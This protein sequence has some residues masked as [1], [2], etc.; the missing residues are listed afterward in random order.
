MK[1]GR[2]VSASYQHARSGVSIVPNRAIWCPHH[3]KPQFPL[4][5]LA[6]GRVFTPRLASGEVPRGEK[7]LYSGTDPESYITE[8]TLVHEDKIRASPIP[9]PLPCRTNIKTNF[10]QKH[11]GDG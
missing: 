5:D 1:P 4:K 6:R 10:I 3:D 8:D 9:G 11:F 7:M 2:F